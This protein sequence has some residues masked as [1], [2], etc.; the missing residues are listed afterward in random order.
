MATVAVTVA[1][2]FW[3]TY[4]CHHKCLHIHWNYYSLCLVYCVA[5]LFFFLECYLVYVYNWETF[6]FLIHVIQ[7]Q[8]M[9]H[10]V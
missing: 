10:K 7:F 9:Y 8:V 1:G 5:F 2:I 6:S 3:E 4:L